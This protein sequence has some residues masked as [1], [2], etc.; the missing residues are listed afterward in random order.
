MVLCVLCVVYYLLFLRVCCLSLVV[1]RCGCLSFACLL[2]RRCRCCVLFVA[3]CG[4]AILLV[5]AC[6]SVLDQP[7][8]LLWFVVRCSLFVV[9]CL[10]FVG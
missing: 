1:A 6:L 2:L 9:R 10:L 8:C 4:I 3:C 5:V 7:R